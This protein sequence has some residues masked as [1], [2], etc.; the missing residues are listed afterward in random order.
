MAKS[1]LFYHFTWTKFLC[2]L[3]VVIV[4]CWFQ[5]YKK[6]ESFVAA[7]NNQDESV[8]KVPADSLWAE[9][10]KRAGFK[11]TPA[12][13]RNEITPEHCRIFNQMYEE[14]YKNDPTQAD[15]QLQTARQECLMKYGEY[16]PQTSMGVDQYE[17]D[18]D[19]AFYTGKPSPI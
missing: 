2:L 19:Q 3:I 12:V 9:V 5:S 10:A 14:T 18:E 16:A 1:D 7:F 17:P 13:Q 6:M 8:P 11:A 4:V 15:L